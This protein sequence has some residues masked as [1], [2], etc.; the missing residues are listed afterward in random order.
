MDFNLPYK[1]QRL[2]CMPIDDFYIGKFYVWI[3]HFYLSDCLHAQKKY[4]QKYCTKS[5]CVDFHMML[6]F[7]ETP[8]MS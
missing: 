4:A 6:Q 2:W 7:T 3:F 5:L 8:N 1:L